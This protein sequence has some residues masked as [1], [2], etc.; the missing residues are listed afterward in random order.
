MITHDYNR[1]QF[2]S[3]EEKSDLMFISDVSISNISLE[4]YPNLLVFPDSFQTYDSEFGNKTICRVVGDKLETESIVGFIGRNKTKLSIFSRFAGDGQADYFIHYMLQKV[5]KINLLNLKH[6]T[7]EDSVFDFLLYVFPLFLKKALNQGLYKKY[8]TVVHND[9]KVK[10][11]IDINR[12]IRLNE[13][14]NGRVAYKTRE[15]SYDNEMTQLVR[16]TIEY[17][18]KQ[19]GGNEILCTDIDTRLSVNQIIIAT[20]SF[21]STDVQY[22]INKNIKPLVHPYYS[23]YSSLQRICLQILRHEE[24]KYGMDKNDIYGVLVDAAWL[25]E[26]YLAELLNGRYNHIVKDDAKKFYLFK[27]NK[28]RIIPDYLSID[29]KIVADAKYIPLERNDD[30]SEERANAIYYKTIAYM[31]RF[32]SKNGFLLFPHP[33]KDVE[34]KPMEID[35]ELYNDKCGSITKIGLRIPCNCKSYSEFVSKIQGNEKKFLHE[36]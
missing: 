27:G 26:E 19:T 11:I 6:T 30:Y 36:L 34:I 18:R 13:P 21:R 5:L 29:R 7:N 23:E 14:F 8:I 24:L 35:S 1:K 32:C 31:Y 3:D 28:Q 10:G 17:I 22:I 20:P 25:W 12:H 33:D 9:E 2:E 16:H 4:N 15:F